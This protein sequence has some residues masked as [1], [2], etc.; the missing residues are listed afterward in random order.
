M[1][2]GRRPRDTHLTRAIPHEG[3][4]A[5]VDTNTGD[6]SSQGPPRLPGR[7]DLC[8]G[9]SRP[10]EVG[11]LHSQQRKDRTEF[12]ERRKEGRGGGRGGTEHK[13]RSRHSA[14]HFAYR[15]SFRPSEAV[16]ATLVSDRETE[17][18]GEEAV[19]SRMCQQ[20]KE[21]TSPRS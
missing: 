5:A 17:A 13:L 19:A 6:K 16:L 12:V 11:G 8:F 4:E 10:G 18:Q 1:E 15:T 2:W 3:H 20:T 7:T 9:G 21:Y 14:K